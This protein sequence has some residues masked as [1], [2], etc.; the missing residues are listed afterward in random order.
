MN[1]QP[2]EAKVSDEYVE[3]LRLFLKGDDAFEP[4]SRG[5]EE[6]D[7]AAGGNIYAALMAAAL[8]VAVSDP[9]TRILTS[10][11]SWPWSAARSSSPTR[12]STR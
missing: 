1:N 10:S 7:G 6:R 9:P 2:Y 4:L 3:A 12:T 8:H 11:G 5:L